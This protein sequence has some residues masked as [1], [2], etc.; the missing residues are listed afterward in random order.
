MEELAPH[1]FRCSDPD[2]FIMVPPPAGSDRRDLV[3]E[4][5][6][7]PLVMRT[8]AITATAAVQSIGTTA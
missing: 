4:I 6:F 3:L 1:I 8:P 7:R 2:G 5:V